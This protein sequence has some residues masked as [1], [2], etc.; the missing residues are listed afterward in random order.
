V[1]ETQHMLVYPIRSLLPHFTLATA[2]GELMF[3]KHR[4]RKWSPAWDYVCC[5]LWSSVV[6][7][8]GPQCWQL[9]AAVR[10]CRP[11][12]VCRRATKRHGVLF[13]DSYVNH[14]SHQYLSC[15]LDFV[16]AFPNI[17]PM[18]A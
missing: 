9:N 3:T 13:P 18:Q 6:R 4:V 7:V 12:R 14:I 5:R 11:L 15:K 16:R 1:Y 10:A 8:S 17:S 2:I